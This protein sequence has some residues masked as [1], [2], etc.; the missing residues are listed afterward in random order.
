MSQ[1]PHQLKA[2]VRSKAVPAIVRVEIR[3]G[4]TLESSIGTVMHAIRAGGAF[5]QGGMGKS[6]V[7]ISISAMCSKELNVKVSLLYGPG[8]YDASIK[9]VATGMV[10]VA[11][12]TMTRVPFE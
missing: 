4:K 5:G 2:E 6:D 9:L 1:N 7:T 10:K 12:L 8:N 3:Y 11:P